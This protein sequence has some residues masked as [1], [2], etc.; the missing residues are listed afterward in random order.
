MWRSTRRFVWQAFRS[1]KG[2]APVVIVGGLLLGALATAKSLIESRLVDHAYKATQGT[3][4]DP[5]LFFRDPP[6]FDLGGSAGK[7]E[8]LTNSV[9]ADRNTW[10]V[11]GVYVLLMAA[12]SLV[13]IWTASYREAIFQSLFGRIYAAGMRATFERPVNTSHPNEPGGLS[14]AIQQGAHTVAGAWGVV[15]TVAQHAFAL[16]A[17]LATLRNKAGVALVAASLF[18]GG[19]YV[20]VCRTQATRLKQQRETWDDERR[21]LFAHTD[22]VLTNREVIVAHE[23][24]DTY[25]GKV[26]GWAD[27]LAGLGRQLT[28]R[29]RRFGELTNGI[30]DVGRIS[31]II[32]AV[33]VARAAGLDQV[34]GLYFVLSLYSRLLGPVL[35]FSN[36][37]D[38]FKRSAATSATLV[39]LLQTAPDATG[40]RD[41]QI[42]PEAPAA[43]FHTVRFGYEPTKE[44]LRSCSLTVPRGRV[45]MLL[46]RSGKGKTTVARLM[47]GFLKAEAG[48]VEVLGTD[49]KDWSH[50]ALLA[51]MSYLSQNRHV[52]EGSIHENLFADAGSVTTQDEAQALVD[53]GL[54]TTLEEATAR[55]AQNAVDLSEGQKQ[56]LALARILVDRSEIAILDEPLA[57]VDSLTFAEVS[58]PLGAWLADHRRTVLLVTHRL[59]FAR[60]ADH[61]VI[62]DD[63]CVVEEG[64]APALLASPNSCYRR[65][66]EAERD[67]LPAL[68]VAV[69]LTQGS[70]AVARSGPDAYDPDL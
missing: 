11:V 58:G 15:L 43:V 68:P 18:I 39:G 1:H 4:P 16:V 34:G 52:V 61:V 67:G 10:A 23:R 46:G 45:T 29:E 50:T 62:L 38:D 63:G 5:D 24:T 57:G 22:D 40:D 21:T 37:Y 28:V 7:V 8:Q 31:T 56:R 3:P 13:A 60:F 17:V 51:R 49:V 59:A 6:P 35:G 44:V 25:V 36:A 53:V 69:D 48:S 14:G 9:L 65:I 55:L 64:E 70:P 19:V 30:Y 26:V 54:A 41:P 20:L 2:A 12:G 66:L 33:L 27:R 47:L 42:A 32:V